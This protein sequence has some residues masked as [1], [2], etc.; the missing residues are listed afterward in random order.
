[1]SGGSLDYLF[2]DV[3]E[4]KRRARLDEDEAE[5][6]EGIAQLLHDLEWSLSGDY[7]SHQYRQTLSEFAGTWDGG[8][9]ESNR[10]VLIP[11]SDGWQC[12]NHQWVRGGMTVSEGKMVTVWKCTDCPAWTRQF[13]GRQYEVDYKEA[14]E[15]GADR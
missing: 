10:S 3:R 1:M 4:V 8:Y 2:Q 13:H 11:Q 15:P 5:L 14:G 9:K 7:A 6:L 12:D